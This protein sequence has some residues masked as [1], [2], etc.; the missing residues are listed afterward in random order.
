[1]PVST[2]DIF[3]TIATAISNNYKK[4]KAIDGENILTLLSNAQVSQKRD[5]FWH[6][7]H[8]SNQGGKPGSVIREG[9]YKLIYNYEDESSELYD[10]VNDIGEKKNIALANL[11]IEKQLKAKLFKWLKDNHALMP[12]KNPKYNPTSVAKK[13]GQDE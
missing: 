7:P 11:Q 2:A 8:Y 10:I 1:M 9:N 6:Y 4:D 5:L 12:I 3:P 13:K